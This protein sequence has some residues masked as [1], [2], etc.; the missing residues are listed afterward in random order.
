MCGIFSTRKVR[1]SF[2]FTTRCYNNTSFTEF[3]QVRVSFNNGNIKLIIYKYIPVTPL[4]FLKCCDWTRLGQCGTTNIHFIEP[5]LTFSSC[6]RPK[7]VLLY[8]IWHVLFVAQFKLSLRYW[9]YILYSINDQLTRPHI[10]VCI[11]RRDCMMSTS[12]LLAF[13]QYGVCF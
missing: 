6:V 13:V 10:Y 8:V 11:N 1:N 9:P 12:F 4:L 2:R 7:S 3:I 5:I